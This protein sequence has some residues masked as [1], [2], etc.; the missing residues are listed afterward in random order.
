MSWLRR[1]LGIG[2]VVCGIAASAAELASGQQLQHIEHALAQLEKTIQATREQYSTQQV[3]LEQAE[4]RIGELS[5]NLQKLTK[6]LAIRTNSLDELQLSRNLQTQTLH[7]QQAELARQI[8]AAY[9]VG[10]QDYLKLLLNQQQPSSLGRVLTYYDY[11]NRAYYQRIAQTHET[12]KRLERLE[13]EIEQEKREIITL[14]REFSEQKIQLEHKVEER[15]AI[16]RQLSQEWENQQIHITM[17][18]EDKAQLRQVVNSAEQAFSLLSTEVAVLPFAQ[19][20][21]RLPYP[22]SGKVLNQFG[23]LRGLGSLRWQGILLAANLGDEVRA[24]ADGR[25]VFAHWMRNYGQLLILEHD[26]GYMTLYGHNQTLFKQ[27]GDTVKQGEIIASAGDSGG[28][29]LAALYFE[30]RRN[31][32]PLNPIT[33]LRAMPALSP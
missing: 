11:F 7:D 20:K 23:A 21:G 18:E 2:F 29:E 10:R 15:I 32:E 31:G 26:Q 27:T 12:L 19:Q 22:L 28:Q 13:I 14:Q 16:M 4:K 9:L 1:T 17:L 5:G 33:W 8:R 3:A 6:L 25:V 24:V 30:I